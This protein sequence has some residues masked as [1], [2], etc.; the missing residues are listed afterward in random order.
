MLS[1]GTH[2]TCTTPNYQMPF[3]LIVCLSTAG[4]NPQS[5][6]MY[7]SQ[8]AC[9]TERE[10]VP[11]TQS[12]GRISGPIPENV[13][14]PGYTQYNTAHSTTLHTVQ[15]QALC[16][17]CASKIIFV[18]YALNTKCTEYTVGIKRLLKWG[19]FAKGAQNDD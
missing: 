5:E 9:T 1:T 6:S 3:K 18:N 10:H 11:Q 19:L 13:G 16:L 4:G 8:R 12:L 2:T 14:C 15:K 7:H 17:F